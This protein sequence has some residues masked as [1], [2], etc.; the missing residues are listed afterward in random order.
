[1]VADLPFLYAERLDSSRNMARFYAL[2]IEPTL[3][4]EVSLIRR[5][6]RIGSHGQ[7]KTM[8]FAAVDAATQQFA[9]I[10]RQKMRRGYRQRLPAAD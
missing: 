4:G 2:S 7:T 5:W 8:V 10:R 9:E 1:M 6:G 3:F